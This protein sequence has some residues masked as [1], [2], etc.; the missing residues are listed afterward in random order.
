MRQSKTGK[1]AERETV[2][3]EVILDAFD[4]PT[5]PVHAVTEADAAKA[6]ESDPFAA[7]LARTADFKGKPGQLLVIPNAEGAIDRVLFTVGDNPN[8]FRAL[9][10]KLPVGVYR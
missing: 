4:G 1:S 6:L 3:S 5:I 10:A 7:A 8:A 9:P 2:M